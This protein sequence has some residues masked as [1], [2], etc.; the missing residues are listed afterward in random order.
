MATPL[1]ITNSH[2]YQP[3][4]PATTK[5]LF[6]D[7]GTQ[8]LAVRQAS[9]RASQ[10][11]Y[12][13]PRLIEL[14]RRD[15]NLRAQAAGASE[16]VPSDGGFILDQ[17]FAK[18]LVT[19]VFDTGELCRRFTIIPF[20]REHATEMKLAGFDEQSRQDG[21]RWGGMSAKFYNEADRPTA[22]K[23]KYRAIELNLHKLIGL[24]Y[25]TDELTQDGAALERSISL[26]FR[27]EFVFQL[28]R[29]AL[30]GNGAGQP[31]GV[32]D[33]SNQALIVVPPVSEQPPW[34]I[35]YQ[36]V[37]SMLAS[38]WGP[39]IK[40][41]LWL[42]SA[43]ALPQLL[44]MTIPAGD[45]G[46]SFFPGYVPATAGETWGRLLG[47]P[48]VICSEYLSILGYQGD[49]ILLD[50]SQI[51]FVQKSDIQMSVSI[52]VDFN[53]D[54]STYKFVWRVDTQPAWHTALTSYNGSTQLSP[55]ITLGARY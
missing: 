4:P 40:N 12:V 6:P 8:L 39:G 14:N 51:I 31:L 50:P 35:T 49:I 20:T 48:C 43:D 29:H 37:S 23:P 36:N 1:T 10:S 52:H 28:E 7:L 13:D 16:A 26:A 32:L 45:S 46:G 2:L 34:T 27:N 38:F 9:L 24:C 41:G 54:T 33:P 42:V 17:E 22:T 21:S 25:V 55:Y 44:T 18:E 11:G 19:R 3:Q 5:P 47:I 15:L 53:V 30:F